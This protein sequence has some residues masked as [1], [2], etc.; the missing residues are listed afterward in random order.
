M[1]ATISAVLLNKKKKKLIDI[2]VLRAEKTNLELK[3]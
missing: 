3:T 2:S 1:A